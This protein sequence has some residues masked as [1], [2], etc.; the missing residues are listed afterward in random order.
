MRQFVWIHIDSYSAS[1]G[2]N[3]SS[4]PI[5]R[6][7]CVRNS[8]LYVM[9]L[10]RM[11][12]IYSLQL[13]GT[14]NHKLLQNMFDHPFYM[15]LYVFSYAKPLDGYDLVTNLQVYMYWLNMVL[16][17]FVQKSRWQWYGGTTGCRCSNSTSREV[18]LYKRVFPHLR[19]GRFNNLF[20]APDS[21][22]REN[23][24]N[25]LSYIHIYCTILSAT[26]EYMKGNIASAWRYQVFFCFLFISITR[27]CNG[28]SLFYLSHF[29][30]IAT[31]NICVVVVAVVGFCSPQIN[32][33]VE[34]Q[35]IFS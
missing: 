8:I 14:F 7:N 24:S 35:C 5:Y 1:D 29:I 22:S 10:K 17:N 33:E 6:E 23:G 19:A 9:W 26:F 12:E 15:R 32:L 30:V 20:V 2:P 16:F 25:H 28:L 34:S 13:F 27:N 11:C 21:R 3:I 31:N 4:W 18:V